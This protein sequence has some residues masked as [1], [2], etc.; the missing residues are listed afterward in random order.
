VNINARTSVSTEKADARDTLRE[1][2][3]AV[4][5]ETER[6]CEPLEIEDCVVQS[7]PDA[8]PVNWHVAHTTWFFETFLLQPRLP[9]YEVFHSD[10]SYLFN[11]Y[12]NA[13]GDRQPRPKRGMVTRPGVERVA[14][15][16]Q[17][18]DKAMRALIDSANE[19]KLRELAPFLEI[20][21]QHEQQHQE[22]ML[23]DVKNLLSQNPLK[24]AYRAPGARSATQ[25]PTLSWVQFDEG[26]R[27]I[28]RQA[29]D[30]CF[31]NEMP[32]HKVYVG[33]FRIA[34]RLL[35]N[36]EYLAFI[37]DG[38]YERAEL[39]LDDGWS[40]ILDRGWRSPLYW[41]HDGERWLEFTLAG[42]APLDP[43]KPVCHLSF[44]E[45]DAVARWSGARLPTEAEWET[46]CASQRIAGNFV[47]S[48]I[49]HP[50]AASDASEGSVRQAF[51][52]CWEWTRSAYEPYPGYKPPPGAFGEYNGKFMCNQIVLRGG[53][54]ATPRSHV[55]ATYRNFFHPDKRWQFS[56]VRL[57]KDA[58]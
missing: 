21:L 44:Y 41:R 3:D 32:R 49:L 40:A 50:V 27:E 24:P 36:G 37:E 39:W 25:A 33:A 30:F 11:S 23:T 57:A 46:A 4:R 9:G 6:L 29:G 18:V 31:D 47:E 14:L 48:G 20:G 58:P 35:T 28:G 5:T 7:M 2:Y 34:D 16:R 17:Y 13:V 56:G 55:R 19:E 22:L 8:S 43:H 54:C 45:A 42:G 15:Y 38:G 26:L 12:Y 52:D 10:F 53:S 51:G 1:R